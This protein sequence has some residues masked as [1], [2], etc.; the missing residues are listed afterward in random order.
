[1]STQ[2]EPENPLSRRDALAAGILAGAGL[3]L[4][5]AGTSHAADSAAP[6]MK[7]IPSSGE[8]IPAVGLGT[9]AFERGASEAIQA[10]I[11]RMHELGGKVIDTAAAYG[12]SEALIGESLAALG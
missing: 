1:M 10:E 2:P 11:K 5:A 4:S 6:L 12:D 8:R 3:I 9:D 7:V